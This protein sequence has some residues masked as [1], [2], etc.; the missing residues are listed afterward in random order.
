MQNTT[1]VLDK[2]RQRDIN[3]LITKSIVEEDVNMDT[4]E[5]VIILDNLKIK[6]SYIFTKGRTRLIW[7]RFVVFENINNHVISPP[8]TI[9]HVRDTE[10]KII[11]YIGARTKLDN[12]ITSRIQDLL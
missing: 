7:A 11:E 6:K 5:Y 1:E 10:K 8:L 2:L 4:C 3:L 9:D 12:N